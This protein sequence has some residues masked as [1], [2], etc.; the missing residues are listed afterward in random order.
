MNRADRLLRVLVLLQT[1]DVVSIDLLKSYFRISTRTAY[2]DIEGLKQLKITVTFEAEKG[3]FVLVASC[4]SPGNK[5]EIV[6][7]PMLV[8]PPAIKNEVLTII[9]RAVNNDPQ[10]S[11]S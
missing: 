9:P 4:P 10:N 11:S 1:R 6:S 5:S 7:Q 3:C 2:Q 8:I